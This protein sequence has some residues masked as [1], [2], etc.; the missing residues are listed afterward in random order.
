MPAT[1][2]FANPHEPDGR[3]FFWWSRTEQNSD[4]FADWFKSLTELQR[5]KLIRLLCIMSVTKGV[6]LHVSEQKYKHEFDKICAIKSETIRLYGFLNGKDFFIIHFTVK[7]NRKL[8]SDDRDIIE[9]RYA[10]YKQ[11]CKR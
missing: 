9:V 8:S 11:E 4:D 6:R 5:I 1:L 7:K 3:K 10:E 2:F